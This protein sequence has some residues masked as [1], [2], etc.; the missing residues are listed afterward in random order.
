MEKMAAQKIT[1]TLKAGILMNKN[2]N[3][4][5]RGHTLFRE[6]LTRAF[7]FVEVILA[8]VIVS[9]SLLGLIRLHIISINMTETAQIDT[10]AVLVAE[11]KIAETLAAGYTNLAN[12]SGTVQKNALYF[13]WQTQVTD[14]R[15]PQLDQ[16]D[17]RGLSKV[18]VDVTWKQGICRKH[19]QMSTCVAD[20]KLQ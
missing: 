20:R 3:K 18:S 14:M 4:I 15:L 11:E 5:E 10:Q 7:T 1:L 9:I 12:N 2:Y 8:L 6:A 16:A 17:I 19:L 13:N